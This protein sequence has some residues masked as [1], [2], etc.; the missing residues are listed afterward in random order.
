MRKNQKNFKNNFTYLERKEKELK[1]Y[2]LNYVIKYM[3]R[4]N[5]TKSFSGFKNRV[6]FKIIALTRIQYINKFLFNKNKNNIKISI[7]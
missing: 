4:K 6:L 5:Y 2:F 3:I 7:I 1:H